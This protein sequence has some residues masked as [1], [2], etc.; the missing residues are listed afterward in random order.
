MLFDPYVDTLFD[1][2]LIANAALGGGY[3]ALNELNWHVRTTYS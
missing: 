2:P 1:Y 3:D